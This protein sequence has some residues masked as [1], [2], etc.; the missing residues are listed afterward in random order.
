M[1]KKSA[2]NEIAKIMAEILDL[3]KE[4]MQLDI[5]NFLELVK[6]AKT[7][8]DLTNLQEKAGNIYD[9][10]KHAQEIS[11]ALNNKRRELGCK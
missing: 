9:Y 6:N 3:H 4:A 11:Q 1:I 5:K 8:N 2:A 10:E 7:C